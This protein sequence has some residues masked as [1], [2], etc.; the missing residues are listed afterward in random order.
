VSAGTVLQLKKQLKQAKITQDEVA[1]EAGV[2][3]TMVVHFLAGRYG[4][5][6]VRTAAEK[7][8]AGRR[9]LRR[10]GSSDPHPQTAREGAAATAGISCAPPG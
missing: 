3:R 7:L 8:L 4:S 10:R 2:G 5:D 9:R 6:R 1:A